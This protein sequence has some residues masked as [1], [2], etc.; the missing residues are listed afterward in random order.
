MA[1]RGLALLDAD[2]LLILIEERGEL[3]VAASSGAGSVRLRVL[4][5]QGSAIGAVHLAGSPLALDR[6]RGS[7]AAWLYELGLEARAAL[8][9][10]LGMEGQGGP[11]DRAAYPRGLPRAGQTSA[12]GLRGKRLAAARGGALRRARAPAIRHASTRARADALGAR[13]PRRDHPGSRGAAVG[14]GPRPGSERGRGAAGRGRRGL[15]GA[16]ARDR[17]P[18][19]PDHRAAPGGPGRA[20][21]GAG[22]AGPR[23][24]R[25]GDRRTRGADRDRARRRFR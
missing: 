15:G 18:A 24:T 14:A 19:P 1:D 10:P 11:G 7:E 5:V 20:R 6:P 2:S 12:R 9:E 3:R 16:G 4:P 17:R 22:P 13:D 8:V 23:A 21:P 25:P